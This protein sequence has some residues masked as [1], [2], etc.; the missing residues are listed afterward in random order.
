MNRTPRYGVEYRIIEN[1]GNGQIQ[2][3]PTAFISMGM[4]ACHQSH[5]NRTNLSI[6]I[7]GGLPSTLRLLGLSSGA[8]LGRASGG[9]VQTALNEF[10]NLVDQTS[11][12][13]IL[14]AKRERV[15]PENLHYRGADHKDR[16]PL[17]P[18]QR[19]NG[20]QALQE[21]DVEN[22]KV[23]Q[24]REGDGVDQHGV[25]A[26]EEGQERL[27]RRQGVHGIQ[28]LNHHENGE[29]DRRRGLGH[30]VAKHLTSD[31]GELRGALVEVGLQEISKWGWRK[32]NRD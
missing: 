10:E 31:L 2:S 14:Y 25:V 16:L 1:R 22:G 29:R 12:V 18:V 17:G 11:M 26:Q 4:I 6:H 30:I 7:S 15:L 27:A 13:S 19:Q 32:S 23:E 9:V 3:H 20:K 24:H 5:T 8:I 21:G 28:H